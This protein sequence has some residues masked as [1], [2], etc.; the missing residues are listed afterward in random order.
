MNNIPLPRLFCRISPASLFDPTRPAGVLI[1]QSGASALC[2]SPAFFF[3]LFFNIFQSVFR[4]D[5]EVSGVVIAVNIDSVHS[6]RIC[7]HFNS[8]CLNIILFK[9]IFLVFYFQIQFSACR[10][11]GNLQC[12]RFRNP[13]IKEKIFRS[14]IYIFPADT[15]RPVIFYSVNI[16]YFRNFG[17][18]ILSVFRIIIFSR[19]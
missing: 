17:K 3:L 10:Y 6:H 8:P 11:T 7:F 15:F 14:C 9:N 5:P 12:H 18:L 4:S 19:I 1:P 2:K 13:Y 16:F